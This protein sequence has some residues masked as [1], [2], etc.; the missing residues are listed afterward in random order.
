MEGIM[1]KL[2]K[3]Y[4]G[5]NEVGADQIELENDAALKGKNAAGNASISVL[6]IDSTDKL[7]ILQ[8]PHLPGPASDPSHAVRQAELSSEEA[9]RIA[10]DGTL[11]SN[12]S[13]EE[14]ARIAADGVLQSNIDSEA[15]ARSIAD[16]TLQSNIDAEALTRGNTDTT[17]QS[18]IDAEASAR[19]LAD[20]TL[21]SNI[22]AEES[23]RIAADGVLQSNIDA[24]ASAR[25]I[26]DGT[27]Q[28]NID[29]EALARGNA[30]VTLQSNIDAEAS[31]RS[32]A[33]GTL[34]SNIDAEEARA[35]LAEAALQS[36]ITAS[37]SSLS[38]RPSVFAI[39][40]DAGLQ[41]ATEGAILSGFLPFSDDEAPELV[42]GDFSAGQYILSNNGVLS[43]LFKVYDDAGTLK[44]TMAGFDAIATDDTFIVKNDLIDS[45]AGQENRS[46]WNYNGASLIKLGDFD[47]SMATG[48]DLSVG[49][50]SSTGVVT[51]LDNVESAISKTVGNLIAEISRAMAAESLV[52]S[53]LD[54]EVIR[55]TAA[56]GVVQ[57]NLDAEV[58][59]A[60]AAEGV[61]QANIEAE[62]LTRIVAIASVQNSIANEVIRATGAESALDVRLDVLELDPVT[63]TYVDSLVASSTVFNKEIK[64]LSGGDITN[65]YVDLA[66]K[67]AANSLHIG[68]GA[69]VNLYED[70]DFTVSVVGPVT[71]VT[72]IGPSASAGAEALVNGD[73][74]YVKG[75]QG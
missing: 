70:L 19:S 73:I 75:V 12:I 11:Q 42:I 23:A 41:A 58:I 31:A 4:L 17:L 10:A 13:S 45:P 43:T 61:L 22:D 69:R 38:W 63:K 3:K 16:G 20:G 37:N 36:Q 39:T 26:A 68:V 35:L 60:T 62:E 74:L 66:T 29:A 32:L 24:E 44:I 64:T 40:N 57:S 25:S 71:R 27:L 55:A 18:N 49:F 34:Q 54:A 46:I 65:Q 21:Q 28:S 72:F 2:S 33:D 6:K 52:Q 67:F 30:D 47:W 9:A 50:V 51:S 8:H 56:E 5:T 53:N 1:G 59:R 7:Q 48:I 15:S 14:S